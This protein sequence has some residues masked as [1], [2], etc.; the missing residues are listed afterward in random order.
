MEDIILGNKL[1]LVRWLSVDSLIL[2]HVQSK[3]IITTPE[4]LKLKS[5]GATTDL[6]IGLLDTIIAKGESV[7]RDFL[8]LLKDD[9]VNESFPELR[10]WIKT[11]DTSE[12]VQLEMGSQ[13]LT[14][15]D[16]L[17]NNI[18]VSSASSQSSME[19][20]R[21]IDSSSA[22]QTLER[23]GSMVDT[24][25]RT[26]QDYQKFL[27]DYHPI[28]V[29][30]VK[31]VEPILDDL[32]LHEESTSN[33]REAK[34]NQS[35]MRELLGYVNCKTIAERLVNALYKHEEGLMMDLQS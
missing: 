34:T 26:V 14:S 23:N 13:G 20:N 24:G 31:N 21:S 16:T 33:V 35:K 15:A 17:M 29:A 27:K 32:K 11:V 10:K 25:N 1:K 2:Q 28:L 12:P 4:Y 19:I 5:M 22:N 30:R 3:K 9:E 7:C 8:N 18:S 6:I